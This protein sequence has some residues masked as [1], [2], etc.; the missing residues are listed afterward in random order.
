MHSECSG[1]TRVPNWTISAFYFGAFRPFIFS[2]VPE[3]VGLMDALLVFSVSVLCLAFLLPS[4]SA[5]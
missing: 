3:M 1:L 2:V 5:Y 4:P